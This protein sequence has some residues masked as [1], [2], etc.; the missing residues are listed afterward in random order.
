MF[1][2]KKAKIKRNYVSDIDQFLRVINNQPGA[3]S[4]ARLAEEQK[5]RRIFLLRDTPKLPTPVELAW[6]DI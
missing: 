3:S 1:S 4:N 2:N 6:I 5:Y